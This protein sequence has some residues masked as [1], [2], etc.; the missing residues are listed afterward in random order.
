MLQIKNS[1]DKIHILS[2]NAKKVG[3]ESLFKKKC[4]E[5]ALSP[6]PQY[7]F[8]NQNIAYL[9]LSFVAYD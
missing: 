7:N 3:P 4:Q 9:N 2:S 8:S 6:E 5:H 1:K